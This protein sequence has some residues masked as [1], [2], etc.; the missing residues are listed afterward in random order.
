V[1]QKPINLRALARI[2]IHDAIDRYLEE[3]GEVVAAGFVEAL[4]MAYAHMASHPGTGSPR[5][6]TQLNVAGLR[7]WTLGRYPYLVFY[8]VLP[9]GI[10]VLRVLHGA[11]DV[12]A[13]RML[14]EPA[15]VYEVTAEWE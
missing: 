12:T 1:K 3:G 7:F 10:D 4:G 2:D 8:I 14:N 9:D 5:Y 13:H 6:A 11:M 15:A